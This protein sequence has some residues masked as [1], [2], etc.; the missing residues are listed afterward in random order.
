MEATEFIQSVVDSGIATL[1]AVVVIYWYRQ[2]SKERV[3]NERKR[4][5]EAKVL[6]AQ[7]REDK[8]LL[9]RTVKSNTEAMTELRTSIKEMRR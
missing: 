1:L 3:D 5:E 6:A 7:E 2:D 4:T 9:I 8:L